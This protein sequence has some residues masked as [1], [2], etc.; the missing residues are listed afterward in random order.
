MAYL[1]KNKEEFLNAVDLAAERFHILPEVAEKDYY[2]TMIL[3]RLAERLDFVVFNS[4]IL[5]ER[6]SYET[7]IQAIKAAAESGMF[8]E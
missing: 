8:E 4:R 3:R 6:V 2:V 5:E 7:A 1:H